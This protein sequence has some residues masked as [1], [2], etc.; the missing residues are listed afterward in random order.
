MRLP[1][2]CEA[3]FTANSS[4]AIYVYEYLYIS[5]LRASH[6]SHMA[7]ERTKRSKV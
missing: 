3:R 2:Q 4:Y 5:A 7:A 1:G 6:H